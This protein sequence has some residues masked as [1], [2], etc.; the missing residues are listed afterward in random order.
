M[1]V[2]LKEDTEKKLCQNG[3]GGDIKDSHL[4]GL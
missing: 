4:M 3:V 1:Q 2:R